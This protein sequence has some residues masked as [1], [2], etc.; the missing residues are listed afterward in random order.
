M[1][2]SQGTPG[3]AFFSWR[4]V[5]M[6]MA[7][8]SALLA[9]FSLM[10]MNV[11]TIAQT[12]L[13]G[14]EFIQLREF[15]YAEAPFH[16]AHAS[17]IVETPSRVLIAAWFGGTAEGR[18]D[19]R[20]WLSRKQPGHTWSP[21]VPTTEMLNMPTWNPVLFQAG[22]RTSLF[23]KVG[24]SPREWVGVYCRS[25]DEGVTWEP[26]NY[27]PAGL[28]GPVRAGGDVRGSRLPV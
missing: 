1:N 8:V 7:G 22:K 26:A 6:R 11:T 23:Y 16:S 4:S 19:V 3:V 17:T 5:E 25:E 9:G 24:P 14:A 21:P 20:I 28:S 12:P 18:P 2:S 10:S 27:L 13:P 15:I